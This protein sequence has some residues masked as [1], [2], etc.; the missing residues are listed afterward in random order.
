MRALSSTSLIV[1][2]GFRFE[3]RRKTRASR[4]STMGIPGDN[5][6]VTFFVSCQSEF[7]DQHA[8]LILQPLAPGRET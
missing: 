1:M 6:E 8:V 2:L 5:D 7:A 3:I 4:T